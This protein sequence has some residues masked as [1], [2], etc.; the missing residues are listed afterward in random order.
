[1][2]DRCHLLLCRLLCIGFV[3]EI[4]VNIFKNLNERILHARYFHEEQ[5]AK[6]TG[7]QNPMKY[8]KTEHR[9]LFYPADKTNQ[10]DIVRVSID[11]QGKIVECLMKKKVRK[12]ALVVTHVYAVV[13][14]VM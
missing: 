7:K 14:H 10:K 13:M 2:S 4:D 8:F 5:K 12:L 9:D 6:A 11:K 1:M 3:P